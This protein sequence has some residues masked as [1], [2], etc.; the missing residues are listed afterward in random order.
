MRGLAPPNPAP[1]TVLRWGQAE[2][3]RDLPLD[4][5]DETG[6]IAAAGPS[7]RPRLPPG[8]RLRVA[9][10]GDAAPLESA[11]VLVVPSLQ[12]VT[13]AHVARLVAPRGRCM[14]VLTTTSGFDH[15]DV[16]ALRDAGIPCAR[17]PLVRRDAVVETTLGM[18]LA[19][20]RRF[21][22]FDVAAREGRWARAELPALGATLLGTV[23]VVGAA[24][25]IGSRMC[26]VLEALGARVLRC[27]PRLPGSEPFDA[28]LAE[29]D[30]VTLHCALTDATRDLVDAHARAWIRP[31]AV[32]VN[33]ARG[34]SVDV[35]AALAALREGR[36]GG[37][38]LDVYPREPA[39]LAELRHPGAILL[40]HAAGWHPGLGALVA[41]GIAHAVGALARGEA[42]PFALEASDGGRAR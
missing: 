20:T 12:R 18:I 1:L 34:P 4:D 19:L 39:A 33:T 42:I 7:L 25:V 16:D 26:A 35:G 28:L 11:D 15:V 21:G 10:L 29:S 38:G 40:P 30:V 22:H 36:L 23:G 6:G 13:R 37:L 9:E 2:Y 32:L 14:L 8:A 17:L 5:G 31:S 41:E 3:E 27:D 24:G